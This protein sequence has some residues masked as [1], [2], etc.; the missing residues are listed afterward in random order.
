MNKLIG[1]LLT[2]FITLWILFSLINEG[3]N[4]YILI[5]CASVFLVFLIDKLN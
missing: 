3:W 4:P 5:L 2:V 1:L